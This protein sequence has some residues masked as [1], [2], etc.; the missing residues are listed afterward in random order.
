MIFDLTAHR[1]YS[2]NDEWTQVAQFN[3][4]G[5]QSIFMPLK[6]SRK[7][8]GVATSST[9]YKWLEHRLYKAMPKP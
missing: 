9:L 6:F 7:A 4:T 3:F 2:F 5:A 8:D 1:P